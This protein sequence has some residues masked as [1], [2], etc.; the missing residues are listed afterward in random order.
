MIEV[1]VNLINTTKII[2]PCDTLA[3]SLLTADPP[4]NRT[5]VYLPLLSQTAKYI[6]VKSQLDLTFLATKLTDKASKP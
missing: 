6:R 1:F 3:L 4:T 2:K 5:L